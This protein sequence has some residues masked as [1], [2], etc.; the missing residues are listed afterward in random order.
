MPSNPKI[1]VVEWGDAFIDGDDFSSKNA[2]RTKPIGRKTV[3]FF[4]AKNQ[5]GIVLA[6]DRYD[7][8]R[9][10]EWAGKLFIPWG[11]VKEWYDA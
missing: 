10:G 11:M 7:R 3:G 8:K 5:H 1:T 4:V 6:T 2:K 9:D